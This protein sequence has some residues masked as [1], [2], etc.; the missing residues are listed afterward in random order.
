MP[1][2]PVNAIFIEQK[3][4][5]IVVYQQGKLWQ[6]PRMKL[7]M[8]AWRYRKPFTGNKSELILARNQHIADTTLAQKLPTH[9]LPDVLHGLNLPRFENWWRQNGFDWLNNRQNDNTNINNANINSKVN[10]TPT[11]DASNHK[12]TQPSVRSNTQSDNIFDNM[13]ADLE[14]NLLK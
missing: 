7:D 13:L 9:Q 4:Q 11:A 3:Q 8:S 12:N 6:L 2:R 5:F 1:L 14:A 10:T